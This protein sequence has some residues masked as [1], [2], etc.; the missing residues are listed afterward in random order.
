[1][2]KSNRKQTSH[3][4]NRNKS[5]VERSKKQHS[6]YRH[7]WS[8]PMS[9]LRIAMLLDDIQRHKKQAASKQ[10]PNHRSNA[11][12]A[13]EH[14]KKQTT[15]TRTCK[16]KPD[17]HAHKSPESRDRHYGKKQVFADADE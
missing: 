17:P 16:I 2:S 15:R 1:M 8:H 9:P 3:A 14:R 6:G 4:S 10:A 7:L 12:N 5:R 11:S 13:A